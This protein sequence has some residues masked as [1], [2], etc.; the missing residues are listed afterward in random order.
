MK[1]QKIFVQRCCSCK[2]LSVRAVG[3]LAYPPGG[4]AVVLPTTGSDGHIVLA[5]RQQVLHRDAFTGAVLAM[6]V[7]PGAAAEVQQRLYVGDAGASLHQA[8][9]TEILEP[10]PVACITTSVSGPLLVTFAE[11]YSALGIT[12]LPTGTVRDL[13]PLRL[14]GR[15]AS[16]SITCIAGSQFDQAGIVFIGRASMSVIQAV[17]LDPPESMGSASQSVRSNGYITALAC[18][19][20]RSIVAVALTDGT[21]HLW[22]YSGLL[23]SA[24]AGGAAADVDSGA[25]ASGSS[26]LEDASMGNASNNTQ[27]SPKAKSKATTTSA[28]SAA[29]L[30]AEDRVPLRPQLSGRMNIIAQLSAQ[31][32]PGYISA[33]SNAFSS[34][35]GSSSALSESTAFTYI[36]FH[37]HREWVCASAVSTSCVAVWNLEGEGLITLLMQSQRSRSGTT[38]VDG[39]TTDGDDSSSN[40]QQQQYDDGI[41]SDEDTDAQQFDAVVFDSDG[42]PIATRRPRT[43]ST[44]VKAIGHFSGRCM[45]TCD[46]SGALTSITSGSSYYT[47]N[48]NAVLCCDFHPSEAVLLVVRT[49]AN[50]SSTTATSTSS[51]G[52]VYELALLSL[53]DMSLPCLETVTLPCCPASMCV[54]SASARVFFTWSLYD[55]ISNTNSSSS[56]TAVSLAGTCDV[57]ALSSPLFIDRGHYSLIGSAVPIA[58][59]TYTELAAAA[60][61]YPLLACHFIR[62]LTVIVKAGPGGGADIPAVKAVLYSQSLERDVL[63]KDR[64]KPKRLITLPGHTDDIKRSTVTS[65][66]TS[67][68]ANSSVKTVVKTFLSGHLQ[69]YR[70]VPGP[71]LAGSKKCFLVLYEI[72]DPSDA[73]PAVSQTRSEAVHRLSRTVCGMCVQAGNGEQET[74]AQL[75]P[76]VPALDACFVTLPNTDSS[77]G[78]NAGSSDAQQVPPSVLIVDSGGY[79]LSVYTLPSMVLSNTL[80]LSIPVAR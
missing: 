5:T 67:G 39:A 76:L 51:G 59:T 40:M 64:A 7:A 60:A 37:P 11:Q 35:D 10:K 57:V 31:N 77:S 74:E 43:V 28:A 63:M 72:I 38:A 25:A 62:Y 73:A 22:E 61:V 18:H 6:S 53:L 19:P 48:R 30:N 54:D 66:T 75:L 56:S 46:S 45:P 70:L 4:E 34:G 13:V 68:S 50:N 71:L 80:E 20:S 15:S 47:A 52:G 41:L 17:R 24:D 2:M 23:T 12:H 32:V 1:Q 79:R 55:S 27:A 3:K 21:I 58:P 16:K 14:S 65:S 33:N 49:V 26:G 29:A 78:S 44:Y 8:A 42:M 36:A 69:P 9:P